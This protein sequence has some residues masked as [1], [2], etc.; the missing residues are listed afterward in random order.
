MRIASARLR[1]FTLLELLVAL[2]L[3]ALVVGLT[4]AVSERMLAAW[5][6]QSDLIGCRAVA[7][8]IF[9]QL[10][11]DLQSVRWGDDGRVWL[12]A[13]ILDGSDNSGIWK[14][15]PREKPRGSAAGSLRLGAPE[16]RDDRFGQAGTWLRFFASGRGAVDDASSASDETALSMPVAVA[17]Q[18]IRHRVEGGGNVGESRYLLYRTEVRPAAWAGRPGTMEAGFDFNPDESSSGYTRASPPNDGT[19]E[20]DP[21]AISRPDN[22]AGVLAENVVDFGVRCYRRTEGG[23]LAVAFPVAGH[24]VFHFAKAGPSAASHDLSEEMFPAAIEVMMRVLT[25]EGVRRVAAMESASG[26][27]IQRP[28]RYRDDAEWWWAVVEANSRVFTCW[29]TLPGREG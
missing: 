6:R 14:T 3:T 12:A 11:R 7:R 25:D 1:A 26:P 22:L 24:D 18:I 4:L 2:G 13:T 20:G 19:Q 15:A 27:D 10:T 23:G 8:A 29:I 9:D 28:A 17:Y 5:S 16:L 21:F